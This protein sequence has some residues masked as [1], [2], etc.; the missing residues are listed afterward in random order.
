MG[1]DMSSFS[2]AERTEG[3]P[4]L[5]AEAS[6]RLE[7]HDFSA[8]IALLEPAFRAGIDSLDLVMMLMR[9]YEGAGD[10]A[11]HEVMMAAALQKS[12]RPPLKL[13]IAYAE[14]AMSRAD[15]DAAIE[16]WQ[17]ITDRYSVFPLQLH[18]RHAR[19]LLAARQF[20]AALRVVDL[21]LEKQPEDAVLGNL[22]DV[23]ASRK[24]RKYQLVA[25]AMGAP[26]TL[27]WNDFGQKR[28]APLESFRDYRIRVR[29]ETD[30]ERQPELTVAS[31]QGVATLP[32]SAHE[33]DTA[34]SRSVWTFEGSVD[35]SRRLVFGV[36]LDDGDPHECLQLSLGPI[37]EVVEGREGWLFLAN[38]TNA[39]IDQFTGK[40]L[41]SDD[42]TQRWRHFSAELGPLQRKRPLLFLIA[43]SKEKARPEFYPYEKAEITPTEQVESLLS[44]N[45]VDYCNPVAAMR[46]TPDS[47]Y[48]SD[49]HWSGRGANLAFVACMRYFGYSDDFDALF[50]FEPREVV[51]DLGSKMDPPVKSSSTTAVFRQDS[52]V[53]CRF[54][55]HF[56]GTGNITIYENPRPIHTRTLVIFGGSSSGAGGFAR[57][58]AHV[59]RRV[60]AVNL[61]GSYVHEIVDKEAADHVI[62][63]TNERYLTTPGRIVDTLAEANL[64]RS[65]LNLPAAER[66]KLLKRMESYAPCEPYHGFMKVLLSE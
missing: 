48:P 56:M 47:Y 33:S 1:A 26:V 8:A 61:P 34:P 17:T 4:E 23:I 25:R 11:R 39:S 52:G 66:V 55:N 36:R 2:F 42:E 19:A 49:T 10:V 22:K 9:A 38:D 43:N 63:Q 57:M 5:V 54:S 60:V 58:F 53:F 6:A 24:A 40:K 31:P 50:A 65:V 62:L 15:W 13:W 28:V 20:G 29:F 59:F 14:A 51:G 37:M 41:L 30:S 64:E 18:I 21:A 3:A 27:E 45:G 16:R 46:A 12:P 32:L 35:L 7:R 44:E